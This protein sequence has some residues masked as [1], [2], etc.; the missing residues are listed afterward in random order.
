MRCRRR[1]RLGR[2]PARPAAYRGDLDDAELRRPLRRR[3]FLRHVAGGT[4]HHP[5]IRRESTRP[6]QVAAVPQRFAPALPRNGSA[7]VQRNRPRRSCPNVTKKTNNIS[8]CRKQRSFGT[9]RS[10]VRILSLRPIF[11]YKSL[12]NPTFYRGGQRKY[13][14]WSYFLIANGP[15]GRET[16]SRLTSAQPR[17]VLCQGAPR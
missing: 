3:R 5:A 4:H 10:E 16:S 17:Q 14:S 13:Y 8:N 9:R 6:L 12:L 15:A 7:Q 11:Y 2:E 1:A